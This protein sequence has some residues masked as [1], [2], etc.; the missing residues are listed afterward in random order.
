MSEWKEYKLCETTDFI[1]GFAFKGSHFGDYGQKVVKIKDIQ[2]PFVSLDN[3][4]GVDI[5]HY[6]ISRLSKYILRKNQ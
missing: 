5:S 1:A 2:P 3:A 4:D 6:D